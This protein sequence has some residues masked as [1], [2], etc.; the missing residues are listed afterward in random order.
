MR[1]LPRRAAAALLSLLVILPL[2][3][4]ADDAPGAAAAAAADLVKRLDPTDFRTRIEA[5][6]EHQETQEGGQRALIVPRL[7]YAVSKAF[8]IRIETPYM[9]YV[10]GPGMGETA[11]GMGDLLA[12]GAWRVHRSAGLAVVAGIEG[13]FDT[14]S[15]PAIGFGKHIASPF[16]FAAFDTPSLNSVIFPGVQHYESYAGQDGRMH[17]SFTQ[18]RLF[19]L[20]RWPNRFYTGIENQLTVDHRRNGRVGF[21]I[22]TEVGRFIDKHW[23]AWVRP[24]IAL[25]GDG[26]PLIYN[27]NMEVGFRYLFD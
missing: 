20:T 12:R 22:E 27:W 10:P 18:F 9:R 8:S 16:V 4:R 13:T 3:T 6:L 19:I 24:G 1:T 26:L 17:Q 25:L 7:D 21:T 14:A 23:A 11:A 15:E 5:R 2:A